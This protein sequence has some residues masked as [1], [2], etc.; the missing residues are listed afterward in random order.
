[1]SMQSTLRTIAESKREE[2]H[3]ISERDLVSDAVD[4][5]ERLSIGA[6]VVVSD[7]D[8]VVGI[9]SERDLLTRVVAKGLDANTTKISKVMTLDPQCVKSSMTVEKA[10]KKVT[11]ERIRHLLLMTGD[12]LAGLISSGDL[13]VWALTAREAEIEGLSQKLKRH[14]VLVALFIGFVILVI[15]GIAIS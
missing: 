12:K 8:S 6:I 13:T 5:M 10:M 1:M 9:F 14:K 3:T 7:D 2:I 4:K 15:I 11:E